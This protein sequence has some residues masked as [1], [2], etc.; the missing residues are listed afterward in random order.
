MRVGMCREAAAK[1]KKTK[2]IDEERSDRNK[3]RA[4]W[5]IITKTDDT[6]AIGFDQ[7]IDRFGGKPRRRWPR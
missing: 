4:K 2:K 5:V 7:E 3:F 6:G 1:K